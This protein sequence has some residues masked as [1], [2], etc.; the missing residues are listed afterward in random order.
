MVAHHAVAFEDGHVVDAPRLEDALGGCAPLYPLEAGTWLY[1]EIM[2]LTY[3]VA[4][5]EIARVE[6]KRR[7]VHGFVWLARGLK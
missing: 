5:P 7:R 1:L 2:P 4:R 6:I 3:N